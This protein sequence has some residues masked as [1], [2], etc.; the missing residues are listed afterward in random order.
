MTTTRVSTRQINCPHGTFYSNATQAI[1]NVANTQKIALELDADVHGLT[2]SLVTNNSRIYVDL[3]GSYEVIFSGI[4]DLSSA[5][6]NKH[7]EVWIAIDNS[8]VTDSNTRIEIPTA[9]VEMT[10]AVGYILDLTA[11][12]YIEMETWGD[13]TTCRWLATAAGALPTRPATPSV[14]VTMKMIGGY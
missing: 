11:G 7:L 13:A 5:P 9:S 4:A 10:V 1:A 6:A 12:Q 3:T 8:P 2:H 14:I